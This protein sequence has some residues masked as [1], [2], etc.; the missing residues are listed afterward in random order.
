MHKVFRKWL[1][2]SVVFHSDLN[3]CMYLHTWYA[4]LDTHHHGL[5]NAWLGETSANFIVASRNSRAHV[6][7]V[8]CLHICG[9]YSKMLLEWWVIDDDLVYK[10]AP[11]TRL[12]R[13]YGLSDWLPVLHYVAYL[14]QTWVYLLQFQFSIERCCN[15]LGHTLML[16]HLCIH[17]FFFFFAR[18][19]TFAWQ[20]L[21]WI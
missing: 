2:Y 19:P 11:A 4:H 15:F 13:A 5:V 14:H 18:Q 1:L 16:S 10:G 8:L 12:Y 6:I 3:K 7:F 20:G 17:G 21:L 9:S